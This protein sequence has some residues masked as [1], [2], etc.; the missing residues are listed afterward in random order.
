MQS[1]VGALALLL[2]GADQ[3]VTAGSVVTLIALSWVIGATL[4]RPG[5]EGTAF[6][7]LILSAGAALSLFVLRE[8][9]APVEWFGP[10]SVLFTILLA[11]VMRLWVL[12]PLSVS[13]PPPSRAE[14]TVL[15]GVLTA[16]WIIRILQIDPSS[17]LS[18]QLGWTPLYM[19]SSFEAGR[20]L[21]PEDFSFGIGPADSLFY[22]VDMAGLV[23]LAGWAGIDRLYPV[24]L[25]TSIAGIGLAVALGF[26][27]LRGRLGAQLVFALLMAALA[28]ADGQ[29]QAALLRH[30]GDTILILGGTLMMV[31]L[32]RLGD[33]LLPALRNAAAATVF[34]V[35][36]RHYGAFFSAALMVLGLVG[37]LVADR[38]ATLRAWPAIVALG[39]ILVV[40]S[41]REI[42]YI[43]DPAPYYP[44]SKLL[45]LTDTGWSY[46][47]KGILHDWGF[48]TDGH[49]TPLGPRMVWLPALVAL[50]VI[51]V[52]RRGLALLPLMAP[53]AVMLL[54]ALLHALTG[55]RSSGQTNKPYL[56]GILFMAWYPAFAVAALAARGSWE[57]SLDR[58]VRHGG[59][60]VA[61]AVAAWMLAG[62]TLTAWGPDRVMEWAA[63]TY[64]ARIVDLNMARTA[65]EEG[66]DMARLAERPL[67]YFYCEPGMGLRLYVGG[68]LGKDWDFWGGAVQDRLPRIDTFAALL[69]EL[70]WPNLYIS[71]PNGY[72]SFM[73]G[74]AWRRLAAELDQL[75][76]KAW[77]EQVI[78]H[79]DARLVIV[80]PP[81][82][83]E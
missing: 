45:A 6:G 83:S 23:A 65:A 43:L 10:L 34:L 62:A 35:L 76:G 2:T 48:M 21:L 18:S 36:A 78:R 80:R 66:V 20:F 4:R 15:V 27:A 13:Q 3:A 67:M 31:S 53:L 79:G 26:N 5:L 72:G 60:V 61:A 69:E 24:Y 14:I 77:V 68:S 49:W 1:E 16:F 71:S 37:A 54:P 81:V 40:L 56:L 28:I 74:K 52:R 32:A 29:F 17:G 63:K 70:N 19:R 55:Y 51:G 33:G 11:A 25:A 73:E 59:V 41:L 38:R 58:L 39:G 47:I 12:P 7:L 57:S 64:R 44:G 8:A 30:W 82:S 9:A 22:A 42:H 46:H 75:D 50:L